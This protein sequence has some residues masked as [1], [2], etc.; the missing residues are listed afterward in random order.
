MGDT[1]RKPF[2]IEINRSRSMDSKDLLYRNERKCN[3][4]L[5]EKCFRVFPEPMRYMISKGER[6]LIQTWIVLI[7]I[8]QCSD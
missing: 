2:I 1:Q 3:N 5:C 8:M 6:K 7:E 4:I